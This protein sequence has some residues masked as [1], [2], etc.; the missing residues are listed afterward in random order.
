MR[1]SFVSEHIHANHSDSCGFSFPT[2]RGEQ[3]NKARLPFRLSLHLSSFILHFSSL[4]LVI[5]SPTH[6]STPETQFSQQG[7]PRVLISGAGLS[8]LTLALLLKNAG[9]DFLLLDCSHD[10]NP[11]GN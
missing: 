4:R 1:E 6:M 9:N 3:R 8:G 7:R 11:L 2:V 5:A 10:F